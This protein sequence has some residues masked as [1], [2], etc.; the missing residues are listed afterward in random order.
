MHVIEYT[1]F[2]TGSFLKELVVMEPFKFHNLSEHSS[3]LNPLRNQ[4]KSLANLKKLT[5]ETSR[6]YSLRH[7]PWK[8]LAKILENNLP[9]LTS[10]TVVLLEKQSAFVPCMVGLAS[11]FPT[12]KEFKVYVN[13]LNVSNDLVL[14]ANLI[15]IQKN[16]LLNMKRLCLGSN[17][18]QSDDLSGLLNLMH[19][20]QNL[21]TIEFHDIGYLKQ[22]HT[23]IWLTV[24]C[25]RFNFFEKLH[26]LKKIIATL[27][28]KTVQILRN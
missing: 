27:G 21:E 22:P 16:G 19:F 6:A 15:K 3:L 2:H 25:S 18:L 5:I 23:K 1:F 10:L 7:Q 11:K 9:N 17:M 4:I 13:N 28:D 24:A 8:V 26:S 14:N 12:L 20:M